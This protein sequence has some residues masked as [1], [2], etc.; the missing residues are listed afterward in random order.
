MME[1][2]KIKE[3]ISKVDF[4]KLF[5][6][7]AYLCNKYEYQTLC[8]ESLASLLS[9]LKDRYK[10]AYNTYICNGLNY[11][12]FYLIAKAA[13]LNYNLLE[14][15]KYKRTCTLKDPSYVDNLETLQKKEKDL[16]DE[17]C[18]LIDKFIPETLSVN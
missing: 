14:I 6:L 4:N 9:V 17:V 10:N 12:Q 15:D 5:T 16:M 13:E 11:T 1:D 7:V 18:V 8:D 3:D 2:R